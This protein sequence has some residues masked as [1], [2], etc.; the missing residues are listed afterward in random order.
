MVGL[1]LLDERLPQPELD[2]TAQR[3]HLPLRLS[4][5]GL[6]QILLETKRKRTSIFGVVPH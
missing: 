4:D 6:V 3:A 5:Q 2:L 1:A